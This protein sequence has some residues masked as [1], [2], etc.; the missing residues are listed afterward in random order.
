MEQYETICNIGTGFSD[1]VLKAAY[2]ELKDKTVPTCPKDYRISNQLDKVDVWF[3][4]SVV[5]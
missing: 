1:E 2:E 5:W 4:P 3:T